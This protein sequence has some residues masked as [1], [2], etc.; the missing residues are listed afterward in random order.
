MPARCASAGRPGLLV[1]YGAHALVAAPPE[2]LLPA[3]E[4]A[5]LRLW[6]PRSAPTHVGGALLLA[7]V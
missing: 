1:P 2:I 5:R 3:P 4:T 6:S 7:N